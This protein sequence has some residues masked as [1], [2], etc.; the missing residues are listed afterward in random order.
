MAKIYVASS[1][2]NMEQPGIVAMLREMGHEVYDFKNPPHG[3]GG[4]AWSDIDPEWQAWTAEAYRDALDTPIAEAGYRSDM[5]AME[6]ADFC[7]LVLPCGRSA[8]LEAGWFAGQDKPCFVLTKDGEEPELMA[9]MC[10]AICTSWGDLQETL[11]AHIEH[12][13]NRAWIGRNGGELRT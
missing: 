4:F 13:R 7:V 12:E 1:W 2:R 6:W 10:T 5:D 11:D 3:K 9:K 8:H